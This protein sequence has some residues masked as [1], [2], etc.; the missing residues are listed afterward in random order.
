MTARRLHITGA[1]GTG[2]STLGRAMAGAWSVPFHD[3]DDYFWQPTEP[4]YTHPRDPAERLALIGQMFLPRRSWVLAGNLMGWGEPILAHLDLIVFLRL[5]PA[6][7]LDRLRL[8]EANR[9]GPQAIAPGGAYHADHL[10][11]MNWAAG[12]DDP[13]FNGR[14]LS[15]HRLW[16]AQMKCPVIELD[17][18]LA[19]PD[20]IQAV[21]TACTEAIPT[22][23]P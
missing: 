20:L 18:A 4:P 1:S 13:A 3:T 10:A 16:L 7:R 9:Y 17:A 8:R 15:R 5:D 21:L 11:F 2:T 19:V 22:I 12:Y 14:S 23:S 6:L